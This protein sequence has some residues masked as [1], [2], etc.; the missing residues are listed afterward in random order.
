MT[1][2]Q[3]KDNRLLRMLAEGKTHREVAK[4]LGVT[5]DM[6]IGRSNRLRH[7]AAGTHFPYQDAKRIAAKDRRDAKAAANALGIKTLRTMARGAERDTLIRRGRAM[8]LSLRA[9]GG[10]VGISGEWVR[11]LLEAR[12]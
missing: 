5:R 9:I 6:T 11:Q 12:S 2:T 8:G 10:V 3:S 1:W 7:K 4:A